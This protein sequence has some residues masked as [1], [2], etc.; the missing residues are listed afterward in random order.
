MFPS[1]LAPLNELEASEALWKSI[2]LW[3]AVIAGFTI[4]VL[5][6]IISFRRA[7]VEAKI[8]EYKGELASREAEAAAVE[9]KDRAGRA[10]GRLEA[11]GDLA[12][13]L[14]VK[15]TTRSE[16]L[17]PEVQAQLFTAFEELPKGSVRLYVST[18]DDGETHA[19]GNVISGLL[20]KAGS[21]SKYNRGEKEAGDRFGVSVE[22]YGTLPSR[23][24]R[25]LYAALIDAGL[26][27][28]TLRKRHGLNDIHSMP[29]AQLF[30]GPRL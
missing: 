11:I 20:S 25:K 18:M 14:R 23:T 2:F 6:P 16:L 28:V 7:L 4:G 29:G 19:F 9:W 15:A 3:G 22:Y 30:I 27:N 21:L 26:P 1:T 8:A 5:V 24:C 10:E 13:Y 17:T 12:Q